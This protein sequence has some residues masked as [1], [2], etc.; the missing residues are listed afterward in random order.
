M[1]LVSV[2]MLFIT[3]TKNLQKPCM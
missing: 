3:L 2:P 1:T